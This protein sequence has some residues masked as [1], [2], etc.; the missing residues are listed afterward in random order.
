MFTDRPD[1]TESAYSVP[2]GRV[3][4]EMSFFDY[5]REANRGTS[6][7][8]WVYGQFNLKYGLT[9]V[10]D[11]QLVLDA[12]TEAESDAGFSDVT[13]RYKHNLWGN[14]GGRSALALLPFLTVPTQT[15][16]GSQD[17]SCGLAVPYARDL[18]HGLNLG[19]MLE[20]DA[21]ADAETGGHDLAVLTSATLGMELT[22]RWGGFTELVLTAGEDEAAALRWNTGLT[23]ALTPELVLDAGLR[24]GLNRAAADLGVFTGMSVRF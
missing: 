13:L 17:W 23:F 10:S 14:D 20:L 5:E 22:E 3:Q 15:A 2:P 8:T 11:L 18:G 7:E 16:V 24:V 21:V 4:V 9:A 1:V 19:L 12:Y 6:A